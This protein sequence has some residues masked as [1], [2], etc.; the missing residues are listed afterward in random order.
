MKTLLSLSISFALTLAGS[1]TLC[2]KSAS[3][4]YFKNAQTG[5]LKL[6]SITSLS[7]GPNGLLLV[8]DSRNASIV[9]ID[10]GDTGPLQ[11]LNK[12]V[13]KLD[14]LVGAKMGAPGKNVRF[15]DLAVNPA[16]GKI[17]LGVLR[18]PGNVAGILTVD[19]KGNIEPLATDK[20][21][22]V[23][24]PMPAKEG[25]KVRNISD[26]AFAKDR[27]LATGQSNEEFTS[28]IFVFPLPLT[29]DQSGT[30]YSAET[31]H[32][33][34]RRWETKA[35]I[36]SFVPLEDNGKHFVVGAFACTPIA[37]FP[38]DDIRSG[39]NI[40]GTSV[41]ELGSG[42]RPLDMFTYDSGGKKWVV[43][44]TQRFHKN[45]FG[46]SK[47]WGLRLDLDYLLENDPSKINEK[48]A[49]RN[50]KEKT[51]PVGFEIIDALFGAVQVD[52]LTDKE[53]VVLRE[54]GEHFDLVVAK[55]P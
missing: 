11:K 41:V 16:S 33:S 30:T 50:V 13:P 55:L 37:K 21:N 2:A 1:H 32:V 51:G 40:R 14:E 27:I 22:W 45:L 34:H 42:N 3:S 26:V 15:V 48:A 8:A 43:T 36:Q 19:A 7:F 39:A 4:L 9:G 44:N 10:T 28:R 53:M 29:H 52:K 31:Y 20:L 5:S 49:R 23:R 46:S 18:Q 47:Y 24:V 38:L 12:P 54:N 35:P 25:A 6:G 17:Y